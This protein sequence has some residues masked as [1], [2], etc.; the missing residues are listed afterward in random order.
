MKDGVCKYPRETALRS[1]QIIDSLIRYTVI[2]NACLRQEVGLGKG[3]KDRQHTALL[4]WRRG[5]RGQ[6]CEPSLL[7]GGLK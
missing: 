1:V 2:E 7:S 4:L 3:K 5:A 6:T